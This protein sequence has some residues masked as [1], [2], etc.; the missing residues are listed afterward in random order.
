MG[1]QA[2]GKYNSCSQDISGDDISTADS[3]LLAV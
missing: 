2:D 3:E 1:L